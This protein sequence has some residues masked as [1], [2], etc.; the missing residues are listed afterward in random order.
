M[1]RGITGFFSKA[2]THDGS[3]AGTLPE[4]PVTS[5]PVSP[6][7]GAKDT[8]AVE[9]PL[10]EATPEVLTGAG[11]AQAP[12]EPVPQAQGAEGAEM[13]QDDATNEDEVRM[14]M[15]GDVNSHRGR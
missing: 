9:A 8:S 5:N 14:G 6:L 11:N 4:P 13:E 10:I 7:N 15:M 1:Q 12:Q 3:K 2:P